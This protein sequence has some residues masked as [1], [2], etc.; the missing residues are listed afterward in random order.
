MAIYGACVMTLGSFIPY[1]LCLEPC[2][3]TYPYLVFFPFRQSLRI[4][5]LL[6]KFMIFYLLAF[7]INVCFRCVHL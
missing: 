2:G 3:G 4:Y 5:S 7:I 1:L 6:F